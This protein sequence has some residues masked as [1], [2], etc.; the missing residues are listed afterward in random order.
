MRD[1]K[2]N[3]L[4]VNIFFFRL[5]IVKNWAP[6]V[7]DKPSTDVIDIKLSALQHSI[8]IL[9]GKIRK[10]KAKI[11]EYVASYKNNEDICTRYNMDAKLKRVTYTSV[12]KDMNVYNTSDITLVTQMS[13]DRLYLLDLYDKHWAGALSLTLY[14]HEIYLDSIA[15]EILSHEGF[16]RRNNW[17]VHLVIQS[18]VSSYINSSS[19]SDW[20]KFLYKFI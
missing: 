12:W 6:S 17:D 16:R 20:C 3:R 11:K 5:K 18:G 10:E 1:M 19:H 9:K 14:L 15:E 2:H 4:K 7:H 8:Q 13:M